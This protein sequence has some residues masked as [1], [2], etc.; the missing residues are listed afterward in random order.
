MESFR[1]MG[2]KPTILDSKTINKQAVTKTADIIIS[3][4]GKKVLEP[5]MIKKGVIL[6]GVGLHKQRDGKFYGDYSSKEIKDIA[7]FYTPTPGGVG[8]VSVAMLM[9][10]LIKSAE[11]LF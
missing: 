5:E 6:I 7:S 8:P 4:V 2:V 11:N 3:A 10:N 9:E 1:K